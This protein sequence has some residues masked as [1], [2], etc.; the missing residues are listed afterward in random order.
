[1]RNILKLAQTS[2]FMCEKRLIE[3]EIEKGHNCKDNALIERDVTFRNL[4]E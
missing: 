2:S 3:V 1:M 4:D